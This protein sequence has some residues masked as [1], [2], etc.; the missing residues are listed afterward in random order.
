MPPVS[1]PPSAACTHDLGPGITVCLRCR[2]ERRDAARMHQQRLIAV[3]GVVVMGLIGLY[4]LG[5]S[6]TNAIRAGNP[7]DTVA[8]PP[9][10][11]VVAS[12]TRGRVAVTQHSQSPAP[13]AAVESQPPFALVVAE[14]RTDLTESLVADRGG[15]SVVVEFDDP[16]MRTRRRDKFESVVRRTLPMVY[17]SPVDAVLRAIPEGGLVGTAD[18]LGELPARG[19]HLRVADGWSLGLWPETRAGQDGPLVVRYR[20]RLSRDGTRR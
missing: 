2:Q 6:A 10:A 20:A 14:G 19:V 7:R 16:A 12:S 8:G 18:L 1:S 17:G 11:S 9:R 4:V 3:G 13:L 15:D 5:V